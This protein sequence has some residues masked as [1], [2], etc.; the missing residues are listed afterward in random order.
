M[1]NLIR[2]WLARTKND[3][4]I[5]TRWPILPVLKDRWSPRAFDPIRRVSDHVLGSLF[6]AARLSPSAWNSQPWMFVVGV[7]GRGRSWDR[8]FDCL[9]G[10]N[11]VWART[12]PVLVLGVAR[13]Y[14]PHRGPA[15]AATYRHGGYDL[16]QAVASLAVQAQSFGIYV[17]QMAGF[18]PDQARESFDIPDL[19]EPM[20]V[21]A[22]GYRGAV[23]NL[24][25]DLRDRETAPRIRKELEEFVF[26]D[27]WGTPAEFL[28][29][30][31]V[32][33]AVE[34]ALVMGMWL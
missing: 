32:D 14:L 31:P 8:L 17:H 29:S 5:P 4:S 34:S 11:Q 3:R 20:V 1:L 28:V 26:A 21:I 19:H 23:E 15:S 22:L 7:R 16:G 10:P 2:K 18:D 9:R 25:D 24:P 6:E 12:A 13:S 30:P 33:A 27:E